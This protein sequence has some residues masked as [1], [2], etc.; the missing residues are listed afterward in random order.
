MPQIDTILARFPGP[1][2]LHPSRRKFLVAFVLCLGFTAFCVYLL[3]SGHLFG[4]QDRT[5]AW[6][7]AVFFVVLMAR[8]L[9]LLLVPSAAGLMLDDLGFEIGGI[10]RRRRAVWRDVS[11]FRVEAS[12]QPGKDPSI[13]YEVRRPGAPPQ[14]HGGPTTAPRMLLDNYG[15]PPE[16][17]VR[18]MNDWRGRALA[19]K[20]VRM[21]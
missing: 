11:G 9:I 3:T 5:M 10:F 12:E 20:V 8:A 21:R 4:W 13:V 17:L 7:S 2:T 1:V 6:L 14:P 16:E 15:L 19:Q 18:L